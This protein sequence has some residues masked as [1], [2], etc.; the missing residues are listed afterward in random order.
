MAKRPRV[1]L[2][3]TRLCPPLTPSQAVALYE[4]FVRDVLQAASE[5]PDLQLAIA[6]TPPDGVDYFES[7]APRGARLLP[8]ECAT[9]GRCLDAVLSTLLADGHSMAAALSSDSPTVPSA[10]IGQAFER[11]RNVDVVLSPGDD[12][13]YY[14]IG[15]KARHPD[16]F[17]DDI[18]WSTPEVAARTLARIRD[19]GLSVDLVAPILDVD[20][21]HDLDRLRR[22]LRRLPDDTAPH[23]RRALAKLSPHPLAPLS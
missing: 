4:A 8:M 10:L 6:V 17:A 22:E 21:A 7:I 20:T 3:K 23:T 14:F 16:L 5:V 15:V 11:L 13:G 9:S 19:L 2:T 1:G 12:G 18:P